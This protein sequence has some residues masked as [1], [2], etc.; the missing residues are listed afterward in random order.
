MGRIGI[1]LS[2]PMVGFSAAF[3][4]EAT[5]N[6][7]SKISVQPWATTLWPDPC[8]FKNS[9]VVGIGDQTTNKLEVIQKACNLGGRD[10]KLPGIK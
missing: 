3:P 4:S 1:T 8:W 10:G 7:A 9:K 6:A 5:L 2:D